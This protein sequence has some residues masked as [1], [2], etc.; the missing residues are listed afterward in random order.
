MLNETNATVA[1]TASDVLVLDTPVAVV[2]PAAKPAK[3]AKAA[4]PAKPAKP[5]AAKPAPVVV[6]AKPAVDAEAKRCADL[7]A[8]A[9][10]YYNGASVAAHQRKPAKRDEYANRI[11]TP[12]QRIGGSGPSARDE[13]GL[14]LILSGAK[15]D[16]SF[17]PCALNLDLGIASRLASVGMLTFASDT[18]TLT[19]AGRERANLVVKRAA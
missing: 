2:A 9:A 14:A 15:R 10:T 16:G 12:V 19:K 11:T 5:A 3:P 8:L 13:S 1:A 4:K 7:R 17:D 6:A 18:F